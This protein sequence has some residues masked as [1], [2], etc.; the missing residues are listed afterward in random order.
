MNKAFLMGNLTKDPEIKYTNSNKAY[1][2][3][4]LA[5]NSTRSK[6]KSAEFFSFIMWDKTA[7]L[8]ARY[9]N[10]GSKIL[11]EG[12]LQT[13]T[14]EKNGSKVYAVDIV[15]TSVEFAGGRKKSPAKDDDFDGEPINPDDMPF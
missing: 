13:S 14:Y 8:V 4:S 5:V 11:I 6:D 3:G 15:A 10:K 2:R 1:L 9:C 7:E 12:H